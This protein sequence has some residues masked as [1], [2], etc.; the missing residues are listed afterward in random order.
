MSSQEG[1]H[2][3]ELINSINWID[4]VFVILFIGIVY[5]GSRTGV[6]GQI[7]PLIGIGAIIFCS[8]RYYKLLS[9]AVFGFMLQNWALP[10][11]FF[12]I[13]IIIFILVKILERVFGAMSDTDL[14]FIEKMGGAIFAAVRGVLLWGMIGLLLL[15][16]PVNFVQ[17]SVYDGSSLS[18]FCI[19]ID[20]R[21][22]NLISEAVDRS[23]VRKKGEIFDE[24]L[25]ITKKEKGKK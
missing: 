13:A 18:M 19:N 22:Y 24:F 25:T 14:S 9:T 11:S 12:G 6:G 17:K 5:K 1:N 16:V 21:V 23:N 10:I 20:A 15:L 8:I 3:P 7:V 2:L 4:V